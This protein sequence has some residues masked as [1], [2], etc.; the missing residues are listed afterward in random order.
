MRARLGARIGTVGAVAAAVVVGTAAVSWAHHPEIAASTDCGG[1]VHF[2]STAWTTTSTAAR[3]N[4]TIGIS[5]STDNGSTF[6]SLPQKPDYHFGADDNYSFSDTFTLSR[7]LPATVIVRATALAKW[8]NGAS[9]GAYRQ[10]QA[11]TVQGCPA[12]PNAAISDVDCAAGGSVVV[13]LSNDGDL[14]A[15]FDVT[16]NGDSEQVTVGGHDSATRTRTVVEDAD[17]ALAVT[18]DGM[19]T[20]AKTVHR[21][22]TQP[23]PTATLSHDCDGM[24]AELANLG[25]TQAAIFSITTSDGETEQVTVAPGATTNRTY[26]VG[27]GAT[28]T[29]TVSS[30]GMS[31]VSDTFTRH[32]TPELPTPPT[33]TDGGTTNTPV[34]PTVPTGPTGPTAHDPAT[35]GTTPPTTS[36]LGISKTKAPA[37][38]HVPAQGAAPRVSPA[39]RAA[40]NARSLPFTGV[41]TADLLIM[42]LLSLVFGTALMGAGR[43]RG[44]AA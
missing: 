21:D 17:A 36:V 2:T 20:V 10:T 15:T 32:C 33:S 9:A 11:L 22:C 38:V 39:V 7:P 23:V 5:Y 35:S 34:T 12:Q 16:T 29:V 26:A 40:A 14:P 1:V 8:A 24:H 3:T 18:A 42:G 41:N 6:L 27:E 13:R 4:P 30:L 44:D 25:G 28:R 37:H 31:D 43:R 19:A